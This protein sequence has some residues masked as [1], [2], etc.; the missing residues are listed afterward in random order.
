MK[1]QTMIDKIVSYELDTFQNKTC[2]ALEQGNNVLVTA[3]TGSGKTFCAEY[4]IHV[5]R[6]KGMKA[7]YTSPIKSLSNQ[8]YHDFSKKYGSANVGLLTGDFKCNP[9]ASIM[10]MTTEL[11][12][13]MIQWQALSSQE[14]FE[15]VHGLAPWMTPMSEIACVVFDEV[16]Y[17]NDKDRGHVWEFCLSQMPSHIQ[18]VGLSAS[19]ENAQLIVDWLR[20]IHPM[21]DTIH[22]GTTHRQVPLSHEYVICE[23]KVDSLCTSDSTMKSLVYDINHNPTQTILKEGHDYHTSHIQQIAKLSRELRNHSKKN[24]IPRYS[25]EQLNHMMKHLQKK[26]HFPSLFFCL[27]RKKCEEY[28]SMIRHTCT[29]PEEQVEIKHTINHY[30]NQFAIREKVKEFEQFRVL[31]PLLIRGI[32]FHHSGIMPILKEMIEL[33]F[34]KGVMKVLIATET[35]AVGVNLPMKAV[36]FTDLF[37]FDGES[38][39]PRL[40]H[41]HEYQQMAGRAGRRGL[42]EQGFVYHMV[43][44]YSQHVTYAEWVSLLENK[45]LSVSS[46]WKISPRDVLTF[47]ASQL[48]YET[49]YQR[50]LQSFIEQNTEVSSPHIAETVKH[51]S[52]ITIEHPLWETFTLMKQLDDILTNGFQWNKKQK[53]RYEKLAQK[54][55]K[56]MEESKW[57]DDYCDFQSIDE[58]NE[59]VSTDSSILLGENEIK[60][61]VSW[62]VEHKGMI[63]LKT[64]SSKGWAMY[65]IREIHGM[66]A[67]E[68]LTSLVPSM[69]DYSCDDKSVALW[70]GLLYLLGE[71]SVNHMADEDMNELRQHTSFELITQSCQS[72]DRIAGNYVDTCIIGPSHTS[73]LLHDSVEDDIGVGMISPVL[74]WIHDETLTIHQIQSKYPSMF[75]GNF[76]KCVYA[77]ERLS[78]EVSCALRCLGYTS[79]IPYLQSVAFLRGHIQPDSL[80]VKN[81]SSQSK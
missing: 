17:I 71:T 15:D 59:Q 78:R 55:C 28:A 5:A 24:R 50:S 76:I 44:H 79:W 56:L 58:R 66:V 10:V 19:I 64:L 75:M 13:V 14:S 62:L 12:M 40:L 73:T 2:I 35:F 1:H 3:H 39:Q 11:L 32:A 31:E 46:Q 33:L 34:E 38:R 37:K 4:G 29:S 63:D 49:V 51:K 70:S 61:C 30:V 67:V 57:K 65:Y 68:W 36:V 23:K 72:I 81:A 42:D 77:L 41:H 27:S 21:R 60:S 16:H 9:G 48:C 18:M 7:I 45:R 26:N 53:K 47:A 52:K 74:D 20:H 25:S 43:L 8:K 6:K 69:T 22:A 54:C 80:Y